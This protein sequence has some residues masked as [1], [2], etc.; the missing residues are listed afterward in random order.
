MTTVIVGGGPAGHRLAQRLVS[1]GESVTVFCAEPFAPY[2]RVLL[3]NYLAGQS[4]RQDLSLELGWV[5]WKVG[6]AVTAINAAAQTVTAAGQTY[7][8]DRLVLA[9]GA[10]TARQSLPGDGL[11]GIGAFRDLSDADS[12]LACVPGQKAV[13]LGGGLLGLEAAVGLAARGVQTTVVHRN[14]HVLNRQLGPRAGDWLKDELTRRGIEFRLG[15]TVAGFDGGAALESVLLDSGECLP[16]DRFI[17]AAGIQPRVRL[18]QLAGLETARGVVCTP[19]MQTSDPNIYALGECAE[20]LGQTV[21]LVAPIWE[22]VEVLAANLAGSGATWEPSEIGTRLKISGIDLFSKGALEPQKGQAL[23]EWVD[24]PNRAVRRLIL[25]NDRIVGIQLYG[26]V[27]D[28]DW[29]ESLMD[30]E[31]SVAAFRDQLI[32]G[33]SFAAIA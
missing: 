7:A 22:Q 21:G 18:A 29:Y 31:T 25:S 24:E 16:A 8:Y 2:N 10:A 30:A 20:V 14:S 15:E 33:R 12:L 13:V 17:W 9:T 28:A 19:D 26:R 32:F 6:C 27:E 23:L 11:S 5:D 3:S 4:S 1:Q